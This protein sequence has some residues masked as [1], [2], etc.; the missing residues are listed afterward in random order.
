M[1]SPVVV[2]FSPA[3]ARPLVAFG[4]LEWLLES[5]SVLAVMVRGTPRRPAWSSDWFSVGGGAVRIVSPQRSPGETISVM[6]QSEE[7]HGSRMS[8]TALPAGREEEMIE[9]LSN[10]G[11]AAAMEALLEEAGTASFG[12]LDGE[13]HCFGPRGL[14]RLATLGHRLNGLV[15]C[16]AG[17]P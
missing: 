3:W 6:C 17:R 13:V 14:E 4:V 2:M 9:R 11:S 12:L 8:W 5:N 16:W 10:T 7:W 15:E 1:R